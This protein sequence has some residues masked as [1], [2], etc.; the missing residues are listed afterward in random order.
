MTG[1][2]YVCMIG[3]VIHSG[4]IN[5]IKR[6]RTLGQVVVG[7][8]GDSAVAA[9]KRLSSAPFE[10]RR[11][12]VE[13]IAGIANVI[14]Q[15]CVSYRPNLLALRPN[16]VVHGDDWRVG[17]LSIVRQ[18]VIE[19]LKEWGGQLVEVPY[20]HGNSSTLLCEAL[21]EEFVLR[22]TRQQQLRWLIHENPIVRVIEAHNS[23]SAVVAEKANVGG[24]QF[25]AL[26]SSSLT[27]SLTRGKPDI[28]IVD[29]ISRLG[30]VGEIIETTSKPIIYDGDTGGSAERVYYMAR[31]LQR[32][33]VAAL[34]LEDKT[35][36]KR[37]SL[38]GTTVAQDQAEIGEFCARI[39]AAKDAAA[40]SPLIVIGRIESLVLGKSMK[41]AWERAEAYC[42]A[43]ADAILIHSIR[44]APNEIFE[45][46]RSFRTQAPHVPL[47]VAPTTFNTT[48]EDELIE[49][50]FN[51]VIY[52]NHLLR[53]AY[54]AM[55]K[56][57]NSILANGRSFDCEPDCARA[58]EMLTLFPERN[59]ATSSLVNPRGLASRPPN[60]AG[61][62]TGGRG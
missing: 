35:G 61:F 50:G 9:Y 11:Q 51:I 48:Y 45:F 33:G 31:A 39:A 22:S 44:E 57:A 41:D 52:A 24:R 34:C 2:V 42:S 37:N 21:R 56:V 29:T 19:T 12:V 14:A 36:P 23:V 53:A 8:L 13:N 26:W 49:H 62:Q 28:E 58:N 54:P 40:D 27:D 6:A 30:T 20:T 59:R 46:A 1:T 43:G 7:V 38:L 16:Y 60:G 47:V 32:A 3:D 15:E 10:Q 18:E 4:H 5:V 55:T 17:Q 25:H